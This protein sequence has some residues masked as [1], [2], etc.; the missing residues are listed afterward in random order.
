MPNTPFPRELIA[1]FA[2]CAAALC[3]VSA[4]Q[5]AP[6]ENRLR[7][8]GGEEAAT[9]DPSQ[10]AFWFAAHAPSPGLSMKLDD[11]VFKA[12][13][14]S[15][16]VG[17]SHA[18]PQATFN[19][20]AQ[21]V[22]GLP[23]GATFTLSGWIRTENAETASM[24]VQAW[25]EGGKNLVAFATAE[26][27]MGTRDWQLV[28]SAPITIPA[29]AKLV[30]VR[31]GLGG[32]GKAWFDELKLLPGEG[33]RFP[34][35]PAEPGANLVANPGGEQADPKDASG[36]A[37]WFRAQVPADGL[38]MARTTTGARA[39][40]AALHIANTHTYP[41]MVCNNWTQTIP[42]DLAGRTVKVSAWVRTENVESVNLCIQGFTD[43]VNMASY[44]S[45]EVLKGSSDWIR[46]ESAP[47]EIAGSVTM[48]TVRAVLTGTGKVWFDDVKVEIVG[49]EEI[50]E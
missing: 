39:G 45:T 19:N 47:I 31:A 22:D 24:C 15:M 30:I 42:Y 49:E 14:A 35:P 10:P 21:R 46:V 12:G 23:P 34:Q 9:E 16:F 11:K 33:Q 41:Q 36:A 18:Y 8:G 2:A 44:G 37:A 28:K 32:R 20:W 38:V 29:S 13:R 6:D 43:L 40:N 7:N 1:R 26:P 5:A 50:A 17:N 48:T 25:D 3:I 27:V 4:A